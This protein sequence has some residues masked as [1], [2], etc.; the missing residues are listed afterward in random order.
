[1]KRGIESIMSAKINERPFGGPAA[2]PPLIRERGVGGH[3]RHLTASAPH[4]ILLA[5]CP[6]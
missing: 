3:V 4:P 5:A 2:D 6:V 1:M